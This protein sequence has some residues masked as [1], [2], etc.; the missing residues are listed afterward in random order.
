MSTKH[1][2]E[3][4]QHCLAI[5]KVEGIRTF[6]SGT[7]R[8]IHLLPST[9][10]QYLNYFR[11]EIL[12][13]VPP[14]P[15]PTTSTATGTTT[16]GTTTTSNTTTNNKYNHSGKATCSKEIKVGMRPRDFIQMGMA[17]TAAVIILYIAIN[18]PQRAWKEARKLRN[19]FGSSKQDQ[20]FQETPKAI[21]Y[22]CGLPKQCPLDHF[23]FHILSGAANVIGP[24][25]CFED[26]IIISSAKN[27]IGA[28]LNIVLIN[29]ETGKTLKFDSFNMYSGKVE[30]LLKFMKDV[31]PGTIAL[32]ASFDDPGT[33]LTNEARDIF[34]KLG[35]SMIKSVGFR[36]SWVFAGAAGIAQNSPFEKHVKN[37]K[38]KNVYDGWPEIVEVSGCFPRKQ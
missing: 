10:V 12:L 9:A 36:D 20:N 14:L 15:P 29:G 35:S 34:V 38:E 25:I 13:P 5:T 31:K 4:R 30:D 22:K 3:Q 27:N 21:H 6:L 23:A 37:E 28:G 33:K 11:Q 16:A 2:M 17:L 8:L 32:V 1:Q 18:P 19:F 24:K 7:L 26:Q